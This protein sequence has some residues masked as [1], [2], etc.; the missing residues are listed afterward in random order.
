MVDIKLEGIEEAIAMF[1]PAK[2]R[3][4]AASAV[5][6]T[7]DQAKTLA[8]RL[9]REEYNIKAGDLN[10]YLIITA[11]ATSATIYAVITG[12]GRG[13]ALSYFSARQTNITI[14]GTG[15][16]RKRKK[17]LTRTRYGVRPGPVTV[18]VKVS[19]GRKPVETDPKAFLTQFKSGHIATVHRQGQKR[20]PLKELFGPGISHIFASKKILD[21]VQ[22]VI[23]ETF[24]ETFAHELQFYLGK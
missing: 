22:K 4:A 23:A 13:L 24:P 19:T 6:K 5:N 21:A 17:I 1:D 8:S 2:A 7:A 12:K 15:R 11:R 3:R 18:Q 20:L 10:K 14:L 9:I 16:G